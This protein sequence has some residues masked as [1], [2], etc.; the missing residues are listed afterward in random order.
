[1]STTER[2]YVANRD[3]WRFWLAENYKT[4]QEVWLIYPRKHTGLARIPYNDAV[5]EALCFGWIDSI[6]KSI[7]EDRYSQ[8]FTPRNPHSAYSQTN[9]ERLRRLIALDRV[10]PEVLIKVHKVIEEEFHFPP[11]I[12]AALRAKGKAWENPVAERIMGILKDE[13]GLDQVFNTFEDAIQSTNKAINNY[14]TLRLHLSC[15][16]LTPQQVHDKGKGLKNM[17]KRKLSTYAQKEERKKEAKK[18]R[19]KITTTIN[20]K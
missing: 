12:E 18:E 14:N 19:R 3:A 15:G 1:M 20:V 13:F 2:L 8:R 16:Y 4:A 7:D 17:W 11:D 5:E 10:M 9:I 6:T